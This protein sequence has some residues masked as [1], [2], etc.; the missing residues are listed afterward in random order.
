VSTK[1]VIRVI[2]T[3][4]PWGGVMI[5]TFNLTPIQGGVNGKML[6]LITNSILLLSTNVRVKVDSTLV[7]IDMVKGGERYNH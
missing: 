4:Y 5:L 7:T 3:S 1:V 6:E 2:K